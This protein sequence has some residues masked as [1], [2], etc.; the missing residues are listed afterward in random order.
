MSHGEQPQSQHSEIQGT[1]LYAENLQQREPVT[2]REGMGQT[3]D[4]NESRQRTEEHTQS[5]ERLHQVPESLHQDT[6]ALRQ[7]SAIP[8]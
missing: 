1:H 7:G 3:D 8:L 2:P 5:T 6:L 4:V